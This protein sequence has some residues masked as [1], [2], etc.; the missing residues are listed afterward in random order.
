MI[1]KPAIILASLCALALA[2]LFAVPFGTGCTGTV[3]PEGDQFTIQ[4]ITLEGTTQN[5]CS[6]MVEMQ[7][8][9]DGLEDT[10]WSAEFLLDG[11]DETNSLPKDTGTEQTHTLWVKATQTA[12]GAVHHKKVTIT[13][14]E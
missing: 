6:V 5:N 11:K 8:D 9:Q 7:P 12:D 14:H 1:M 3:Y 2:A 4:A 10:A 13:L